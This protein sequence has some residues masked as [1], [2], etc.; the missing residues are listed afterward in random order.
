[1]FLKVFELVNWRNKRQ[2]RGISQKQCS[3]CRKIREK[4]FLHGHNLNF[5]CPKFFSDFASYQ[6]SEVLSP[7]SLTDKSFPKISE[8]PPFQQKKKS[9]Q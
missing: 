9:S 4:T 7:P 6:L 2:M 8:N 3:F 5:Q 1:M